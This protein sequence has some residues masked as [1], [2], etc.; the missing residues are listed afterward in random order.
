MMVGLIL[1]EEVASRDGESL[2]VESL[3]AFSLPA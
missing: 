2:Q 3:P 1:Q